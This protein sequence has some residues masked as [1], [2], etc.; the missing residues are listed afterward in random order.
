MARR[1]PLL[2]EQL[3][4]SKRKV[5]TG[6]VRIGKQTV[7]REETID[8]ALL[9]EKVEVR[10]VAVNRPVEHPVATRVEGNTTIISLHA[11]VPVVTTQL[12][13]VEELHV[14]IRK[15][16]VQCAATRHAPARTAQG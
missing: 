13:V 12:M 8:P 2:K 5:R 1:I 4:V 14:S 3:D 9:R 16:N 10:R 6:K 15:T 7:R 11:E